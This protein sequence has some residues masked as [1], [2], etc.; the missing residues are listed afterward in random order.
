MAKDPTG[1][2]DSY[3]GSF[4]Y[5]YLRNDQD[6][7]DAAFFASGAA[8]I[9]VEYSGPDFPLDLPAVEQRLSRLLQENAPQSGG[10]RP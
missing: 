10:S 3:A 1:A 6:L 7:L 5:R 8:S 9:M 2:G 4:I